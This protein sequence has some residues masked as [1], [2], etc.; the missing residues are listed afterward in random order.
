MRH[1][2]T[3]D[4][5]PHDHELGGPRSFGRRDVQVTVRPVSD[6]TWQRPQQVDGHQRGA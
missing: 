3:W 4:F 1:S 5:T 2:V 6:V